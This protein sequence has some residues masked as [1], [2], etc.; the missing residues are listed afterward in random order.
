MPLQ[1][2]LDP[3]RNGDGS[4]LTVLTEPILY[5]RKPTAAECQRRYRAGQR[6]GKG[7]AGPPVWEE[8]APNGLPWKPYVYRGTGRDTYDGSCA[9]EDMAS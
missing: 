1:R 9:F 2:T 8:P 7:R 3:A 4:R 6:P 5:P